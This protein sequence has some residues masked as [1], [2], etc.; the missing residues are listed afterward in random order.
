MTEF[1]QA[2]RAD[3]LDRRLLPLLALAGVALVAALAYVVLGGG[4]SPSTPPVSPAVAA[5]AAAPTGLAATQTTPE[6]AVAEVTSGA[7]EQRH[8]S[9]RD[10][11]APLPGV[12]AAAAAAASGSS[13]SGST[14]G[15][16]SSAGSSSGGSSSSSSSGSTTE[17]SGTSTQK[18]GGSS[19]QKPVT[20]A[21]PKSVYHV[22]V[23]FGVLPA[24]VT[25]EGAALT[26]YE[27]LKLLSPIPS[28]QQPLLVFRGVTVGG[29]SATFTLVSEA[30]LHGSAACLPS[31]SQCQAIDLKPGQS[32]QLEYVS[33]TGEVSVYELRIVSIVSTKASTSSVKTLLGG[34]SNAG[35]EVLRRSGLTAIPYLH[36][37]ST[38]GVLVFSQ[39][40]A[41]TARAHT[42]AQLSLR[43]WG[44][45]K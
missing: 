19:P 6:K 2:L 12:K 24:G 13:S 3:L 22:A 45:S 23:L 40:G 37:S 34:E 28:A 38:A 35:R 9:A 11:F 7:P 20:P 41:L 15:A 27:S 5:A 16:S 26:P 17:S 25:P 14:S 30:I 32:E 1:L 21:K 29:K 44:S 42:A 43:P 8:G 4:S 33:A 39:H 36:A 18:S 10:P 31:A